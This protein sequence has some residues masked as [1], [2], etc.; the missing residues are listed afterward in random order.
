MPTH[1]IDFSAKH[2]SRQKVEDH[3][4][5]NYLIGEESFDVKAVDQPHLL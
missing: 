1:L 3:I 2:C 4:Q 5:G